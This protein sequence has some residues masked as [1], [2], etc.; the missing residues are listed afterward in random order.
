MNGSDIA[1]KGI[2]LIRSGQTNQAL[3][4]YKIARENKSL[5]TEEL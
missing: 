1:L 5:N 4:L 2:D 3:K